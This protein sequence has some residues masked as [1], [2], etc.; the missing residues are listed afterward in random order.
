ASVASGPM[1]T[2]NWFT[3]NFIFNPATG[4]VTPQKIKDNTAP[5]RWLRESATVGGPVCIPK[6]YDGRNRTFWVFGYQSHNRKRGIS[7]QNSVP[8]GAERAG[9][10]SALLAIGPQYQIYDPLT[11]TA[12]ANGRFSRQPLPG[13]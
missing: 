8:T 13:N 5:S 9:D 12:A 1:I 11:T 3:D 4:P 2:R 10:F 7:V 6:V